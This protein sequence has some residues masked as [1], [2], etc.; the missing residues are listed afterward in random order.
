MSI[1]LITQV[2]LYAMWRAHYRVRQ[3]QY[4]VQTV[5]HSLEFIKKA[6]LGV[7]CIAAFRLTSPDY[8]FSF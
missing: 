4:E 7:A 3:L 5:A 6:T 8:C 1:C 2:D